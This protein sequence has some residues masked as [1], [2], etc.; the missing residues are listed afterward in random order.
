VLPTTRLLCR[1]APKMPAVFPGARLHRLG[2]E[3]LAA[4]EPALADRLF[5]CAARAYRRELA[6]EPLAR[7]RVHQRV[8]RVRA[9]RDA[10]EERDL[11]LAIERGMSQLERIEELA[12]PFRLVSA[13]TLLARWILRERGGV[14][15]LRATE[16]PVPPSD[17]LA[18]E[19]SAA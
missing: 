17:A 18:I 8:A 3:A 14:S 4:G 6:I 5:E 13:H 1:L 12:P 9:T 11:V 15:P 16:A 2:L 10:D 19:Q 7:A